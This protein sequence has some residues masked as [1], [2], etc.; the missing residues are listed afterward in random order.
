M[1]LKKKRRQIEFN[2]P[3]NTSCESMIKSKLHKKVL[4][5]VRMN[6]KHKY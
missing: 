5:L 1:Q 3:Y 2:I 6:K 4:A